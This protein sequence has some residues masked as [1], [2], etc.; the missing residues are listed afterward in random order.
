MED[1]WTELVHCGLNTTPERPLIPVVRC[2]LVSHG[3]ANA[4]ADFRFDVHGVRRL[5]ALFGL[6][7]T[8]ITSSN[9]RCNSLE[10]ISI[11]LYRLSYPRRLLD[12]SIKFGRS[13]S[14]LCRIF[15]CMGKSSCDLNYVQHLTLYNCD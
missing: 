2:N 15:L 7:E 5:A 12:M 1:S 8:V 13:T 14:S 3:N 4:E 11:L 6:P 10:A 9:D